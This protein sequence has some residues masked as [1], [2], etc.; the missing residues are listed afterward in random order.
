MT[1]KRRHYFAAGTQVIW[2]VG[3]LQEGCVTVYR[4]SNRDHPTV[5]WR[6]ELAEAE[7]ALPGWA[8]RVDDLFR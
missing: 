1:D 6:G 5:Y 2:H 7:P 4:A 8:F 3:V